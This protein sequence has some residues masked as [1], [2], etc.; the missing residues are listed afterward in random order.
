MPIS[1]VILTSSGFSKLIVVLG[2][3]THARTHTRTLTPSHTYTKTKSKKKSNYKAYYKTHEQTIYQRY[4]LNI[5]ILHLFIMFKK[6]SSLL[7]L[8]LYSNSEPDRLQCQF[9]AFKIKF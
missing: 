4:T 2:T 3:H 7:L 1:V 9:K 6:L 8:G 5:L